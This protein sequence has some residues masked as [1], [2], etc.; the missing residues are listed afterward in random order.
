M[1]VATQVMT[2]IVT[3]AR[4][5][6]LVPIKV[7]SCPRWKAFLRPCRLMGYSPQVTAVE[8]GGPV[9]DL[10]PIDKKVE[11]ATLEQNAK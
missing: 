8:C 3:M 7:I 11:I 10:T 1:M 9:G 6:I 2:W 4:L 5:T